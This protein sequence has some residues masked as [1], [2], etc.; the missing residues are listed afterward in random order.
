MQASPVGLSLSHE[1]LI[2][3]S[4]IKTK[5]S[6]SSDQSSKFKV[7]NL[8]VVKRNHNPKGKYKIKCWSTLT[9]TNAKVGSGVIEE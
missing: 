7:A 4:S 3:D 9:P 1:A 2:P 6:I 8:Q 5:I